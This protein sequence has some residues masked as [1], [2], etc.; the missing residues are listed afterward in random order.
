M[1]L[2]TKKTKEVPIYLVTLTTEKTK[3]VPIYLV[4]ANYSSE[5]LNSYYTTIDPDDVVK[6]GH[7]ST[8]MT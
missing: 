2:T 4:G 5:A 3:E 1:A 8:M 7:F 6:L